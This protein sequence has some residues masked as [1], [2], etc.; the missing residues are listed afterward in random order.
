MY[1][2]L[3]I[4]KHKCKNLFSIKRDRTINILFTSL[5]S[6]TGEEKVIYQSR[7]KSVISNIM[8]FLN[9]SP[10]SQDPGSCF[11]KP[12]QRLRQAMIL[13]TFPIPFDQNSKVP[14]NNRIV[15]PWS[16]MGSLFY[17]NPLPPRHYIERVV[18]KRRRGIILKS[19][20]L[21][22]RRKLHKFMVKSN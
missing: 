6:H 22:D 2:M 11:E 12:N 20:I 19:I 14:I 17:Q 7:N 16:V 3:H 13:K 5:I 4:Q 1:H 9:Y 21:E 18:W 8:I 10:H 15:L